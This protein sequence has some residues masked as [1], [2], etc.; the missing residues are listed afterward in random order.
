MVLSLLLALFALG[1]LLRQPGQ[2]VEAGLLSDALPDFLERVLDEPV[3]PND[4]VPEDRLALLQPPAET[5]RN[6]VG[7]PATVDW[8][9]EDELLGHVQ[10]PLLCRATD[11]F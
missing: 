9:A 1:P 5:N 7:R 11:D 6:A 3:R 2:H 10:R 4:L 8:N